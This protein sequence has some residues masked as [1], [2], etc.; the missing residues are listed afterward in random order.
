MMLSAAAALR[1]RAEKQ[2]KANSSETDYPMTVAETR[3]LLHELQVHQIEL[4]MQNAELLIAQDDMA[5][6][7]EKFTDLYDFAPVGYFTLDRS[8]VISA[9]NF[10]GAGLMRVERSGLIGRRFGLLVADKDR[11]LFSE[12]IGKVFLSNGTESCELSLCKEG[13]QPLVTK[14]EAVAD[15]SGQGCRVAI[16]DISVR[17]QLAEKLEILHT[18]LSARSA[19]LE[20]ANIELEAFNFTVSHDLRRPLTII[21]SYCQVIQELY[22]HQRDEQLLEYIQNIYD[23]TLRMN[24]LIETLLNFSR[25]SRVEMCREAVDLS[26]IALELILELKAAEPARCVSFRIAE[27]ITANGDASLLRVVL[28]NLIGNAWKYSHEQER[29]VIEFGMTKIEGKHVFFIKDNG[30]GFDM[31]HAEKLFHPFER[32]HGVDIEGHGIGLTTVKRIVTR[33]G[34][35][36]WAE[37]E[38]GNG[39]N[40]FFTLE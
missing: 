22:C 9:V 5:A 17:R 35:D 33:H 25:V 13:A 40:F 21:N 30:K 10:A 36:V 23:G 39:A 12:F 19:E 11:L 20:V 31:A 3:R 37:S 15:A 8:G 34:G 28:D 16:T 4:E 29:T 1:R 38:Q 2:L 24:R 14:V 27:G 32:L 18:D 7:L 6:A 26:G